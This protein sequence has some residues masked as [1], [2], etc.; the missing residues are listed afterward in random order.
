L[1]TQADRLQSLGSKPAGRMQTP[2]LSLYVHF[3][4]CIQKCPYCDFNSHPLGDELPQQA[5]VQRLIEDLGGEK[6]R[7][8]G[9]VVESIYFGGGTPSLFSP[10]AFSRLIGA[11]RELMPLAH[12]VEITVEANPGAL[13]QRHFDGYLAAGVN[14]LSIGA[15][16]FAPRQL[17]AL[18]CIQGTDDIHRAVAAARAAGFRRINLDLMHGLPGQNAAGASADLRAAFAA[19]VDHI[20]WY[21]LT[22]EPKTTFARQPPALPDEETL[23]EIESAGLSLLA[24]GGFRRYEV[25]AFAR[26]GQE[27]RHNINYWR[28]G[29]YI[30]I[31]AGAHGKWSDPAT[32]RIL[33]TTK[34][35]QPR[36][37]LSAADTDLRIERPIQAAELPA[38]F[39]LNVLRLTE[40]VPSELFARRTGLPFAQITPTVNR[41]VDRQLLQPG[42]LALTP[43]GLRFLDSVVAEFL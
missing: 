5:Y 15:Q 4:W 8:Y 33:R 13:D 12:N 27:A 21:Q 28:F 20:S 6:H 38:E 39:M 25:S 18:G 14:R 30:G 35:A 41:L 2:P 23:A 1:N 3:P 10:A 43:T 31:G 26:P 17:R 34:P 42:R 29:D 40:G 37:Y 11:I 36:L 22:I 7:A 24:S 19:G 9:R 32:G 16:S